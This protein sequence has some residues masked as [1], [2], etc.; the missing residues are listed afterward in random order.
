[1]CVSCSHAFL[2]EFQTLLFTKGVATNGNKE[3]ECSSILHIKI[4]PRTPSSL[5]TPLPSSIPN[6]SVHLPANYPFNLG[7]FFHLLQPQPPLTVVQAILVLQQDLAGLL[8]LCEE[9]PLVLLQ[10][11]VGHDQA[12]LEGVDLLLVLP[13]LQRRVG[14]GG[15]GGA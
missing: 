9:P 8:F 12:L 3:S 4:A 1:M 2:K 7:V 15:G 6:I 5:F 14:V 10:L 13:N 11:L